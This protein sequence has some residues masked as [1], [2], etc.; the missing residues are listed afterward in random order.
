MNSLGNLNYTF[1]Y[2]TG[3]G[4]TEEKSVTVNL[5]DILRLV[6]FSK[7]AKENESNFFWYTL[8]DEETPD[9]VAY[10]LYGDPSKFW[11]ILLFNDIIDPQ[12]EWLLSSY[13]TKKKEEN[14]YNGSSYFIHE[15]LIAQRGDLVIKR[16]GDDDPDTDNY[17]FIDSYDSLFHRMD[18]KKSK[19]TLN[20]DDDIFIFR[21]IAGS[22][23]DY[24]TV[25]GVGL[26][27]CTPS[28]A[29][30]PGG[31][32]FCNDYP[33]QDPQPDGEDAAPL[34]MVVGSDY[35]TIRKK[36]ENMLDVP[37][38]FRY[39][40]E[41]LNPYSGF[42]H[43]GDGVNDI[44]YGDFFSPDNI[45]GFTSSVLY[46]YIN[47]ILPSGVNIRTRKEE[48]LY[49]NDL[50]RVIKILSPN[51]ASVAQQELIKLLKSRGLQ[52]GTRKTISFNPTGN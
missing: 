45:C 50:K 11:I 25:Y 2:T 8:V 33:E 6:T 7:E 32:T 34:C 49:Q 41:Y 47:G 48:F 5:A 23:G 17:G 3:E 16:L 39:N 13:E 14:F 12:N 44:P 38:E 20:K 22:P 4:D 42:T 24:F 37:H 46:R 26:T 40:N 1:N 18:I 35:T 9:D 29:G 10:K 36:V 21:E 27:A 15:S 30:L 51:I 43:D 19:G 52:R 28:H 31:G